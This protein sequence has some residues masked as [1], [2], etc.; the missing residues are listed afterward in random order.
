[1]AVKVAPPHPETTAPHKPSPRH[2]YRLLYLFLLVPIG[3]IILIVVQ[4]VLT[5]GILAA[6]DPTELSKTTLGQLATQHP[7]L[8]WLGV[9]LCASLALVGWQLDTHSPT[10]KKWGLT[11]AVATKRRKMPLSIAERTQIQL[12]ATHHPGPG[13]ADAWFHRGLEL[14]RQDRYREALAAFEQAIRLNPNHVGAWLG[15]G[16]VLALLGRY[17]EALAAF[18]QAIRLDPNDSDAW[19]AKGLALAELGRYQEALAAFEQAIRLNPN[20]AETWANK[21]LALG[22]LGRHQEA[23]AAFEQAIR[24]NP[25]DANAWLN[26]GVALGYLGRYQEA[27]AAFEQA[28]RLDPNDAV[29]WYNKGLMLDKLGRHREARAAYARARELGWRG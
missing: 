25:N 20:D 12:A 17:Q 11:Y 3:A 24:L 8:F 10:H 29:A 13:D 2:T 22:E 26:M 4:A 14:A 6:L 9:A 7:Y 15:K 19:L 23:L 1:M 18:E 16:T 27:L 5:N 21:G 28:I